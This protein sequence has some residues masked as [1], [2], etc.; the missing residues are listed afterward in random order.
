MASVK[1]LFTNSVSDAILSVGRAMLHS[2][3]PDDYEYYM[4]TLELLD[5]TGR[6]AAYMVLPVMPSAI[7]ESQTSLTTVTKS[8]MMTTAMINPSFN[9]IDISIRGTFGRKLR[10]SFGQKPFKDSNESGKSIP[11]FNVGMYTEAAED[12][13]TVIAKTGY[14]LTK[15]LQKILIASIKLDPNGKPYRLVFTNHAFNSSYYVEVIQTNFQMDEQQNMIWYYA[16]ELRAVA[17]Y[18]AILDKNDFITQALLQ[19]AGRSVTQVLGAVSDLV[20]C[21][22]MNI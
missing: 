9:P 15:M 21:G 4:C 19:S 3:M 5:S 11:F 20:T 7:A 2:T 22:I 14:G 1:S 16:L 8:N 12:G 18:T 17:A 13:K 10:V 6:T